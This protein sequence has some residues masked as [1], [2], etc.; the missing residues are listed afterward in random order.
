MR[1]LNVV[2]KFLA[3]RIH[4]WRSWVQIW[5]S[6]LTVL[7]DIWVDNP[8]YVTFY[9]KCLCLW[10]H[11]FNLQNRSCWM[12]WSR[13]WCSQLFQMLATRLT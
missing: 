10:C 3:L 13:G 5:T 4:I 9:I 12:S 8:Y 1:L 6:R 7:V 11:K 2:I